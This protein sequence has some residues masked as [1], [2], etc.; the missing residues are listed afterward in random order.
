MPKNDLDFAQQIKENLE[1][2]GGYL[3]RELTN[4]L[5]QQ[6]HK[7]TGALINSIEYAVTFY[8]D[9]LVL[10]LSY[11][12]Y[13]AFL[14]NGVKAAK[15]PYGSGGGGKKSQYLQALMNWVIGKRIETNSRKAFGIAI[16]IAKTH[17]KKG[18]PTV[19]SFK[20]S[21][22]GRRVGFQDYIL[23]SKEKEINEIIQ[24][25]LEQSVFNTLDNLLLQ[26]A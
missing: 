17:A 6:G 4:E 9:E 20:Y 5:I 22:N 25:D 26:A 10:S 2:L 18:I 14:N 1:E 15:V 11:Y 8:K 12:E 24:T 19:G 3:T 21:L 23:A 7:Y 13:G 16:A